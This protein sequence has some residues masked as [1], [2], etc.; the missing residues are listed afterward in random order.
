M[1]GLVAVIATS[2][3]KGERGG[4]RLLRSAR[5]RSQR[6]F[7][8]TVVGKGPS[9]RKVLEH[10]SPRAVHRVCPRGTQSSRAWGPKAFALLRRPGE[11]CSLTIF[12][13]RGPR[14]TFESPEE[15]RSRKQLGSSFTMPRPSVSWYVCA[16]VSTCLSVCVS[17]GLSVCMSVCRY[18]GM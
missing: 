7:R 6:G 4:F 14:R 15:G 17:V 8:V 12:H 13:G 2:K 3:G 5:A 16:Y 9:L 10:H 18:V 11:P 1:V